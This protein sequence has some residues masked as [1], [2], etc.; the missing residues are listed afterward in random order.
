[1]KNIDRDLYVVI[2]ELEDKVILLSKVDGKTYS[3]DKK[4]GE[5]TLRPY[6]E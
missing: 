5:I 1:M 4:T 6:W 3:Y 2:I